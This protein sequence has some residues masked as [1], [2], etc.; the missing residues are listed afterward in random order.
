MCISC[1]YV[2]LKLHNF[3]L[4]IELFCLKKI[5]IKH[6]KKY[7]IKKIYQNLK[8]INFLLQ[9]QIRKRFWE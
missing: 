3:C 6:A 1:F 9:K 2:K 4:I 7:I 8:K 5:K